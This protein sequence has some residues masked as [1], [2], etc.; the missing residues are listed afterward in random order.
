MQAQETIR[1]SGTV[2]N[3]NQTAL[4]N[5]T[6][7]LINTSYLV[8]TTSDG[9]FSFTVP[10]QNYILSISYIGYE[11]YMLE[12]ATGGKQGIVIILSPSIEK[13]DEVLVSAVRVS[14][15]SPVTHSNLDKKN[16]EKRN[17]GQDIP[18]LLNFLPAVV[19]TSDAGAGV[20]YTGIRV[21]GSDATRVNVTIN[22]IPYND[23]ESQGTFWVNLPD[24]TSSVENLQ[25]Q[26]GVGTSTNGSGAFGASLNLLTDASSGNAYAEINTAFG[27]YN[28]LKNTVKFSTGK[29][30]EH[31]ELSGRL[32]KIDSD[33]YIDRAWSDL[34]SY[35]LQGSYSDN[36][37]L[38]K[39]LTFGGH[40]KT[41][42]AWYGTPLARIKN[43]LEGIEQFIS[44]NWLSTD[45]A[46]NLRNSDRRYNYYTYDN[47]IDNYKQDHYQLHWS[48][49]FSENWS[50]N[51]G[52]NF[53]QGKGYFEQFKTN[54]SFY[55]YDLDP[56]TIGNEVIDET[57]LIRRRWL[58]NTFYVANINARYK[59]DNIEL[60]FG[61]SIS[62][63]E[64]DHYGE[65]IWSQYASQSAIR[66][67]YYQ[68]DANKNDS[69]I[70]G[71]LTYKL[72]NS[73]LLFGDLQGRFV[74]YNTSG[75]TSERYPIAIDKT[76]SF[77]NPKAGVTHKLNGNNSLYLSYA[78][79]QREPNRNDFE[80]GVEKA[81]KLNDFELGWRH[82]NEHIRINLNLYYMA[83]RDQLVLTGAVDDV[84]APIRATS[85][86]SYRT[87]LE[88]DAY[89]KLYE[90]FI[91][92]PN[93]GLSS[94]K[95]VDFFAPINGTPV[96]LG[97]TNLSF[98]PDLVISNTLTYSPI[99]AFQ[100]SLLSKYVGE[101]YMGNL[102]SAV[103]K[104]DILKS[105]FV[106]DLNASY[107]IH[108]KKILKTIRFTALINNLFNTKYISNGY[109]YTYDDN[110][111]NAGVTTTID[112]AGFY[113]QATRNF[114]VGI[115][116]LF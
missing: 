17:L 100:I 66:D 32:S 50:L 29:I 60:L 64:G 97:T 73:W 57:D 3:E 7:K 55:D 22:G 104:S 76:Y 95:N 116:L 51:L 86:K 99:L 106:N 78:R 40:E 69:N 19:T 62:T 25:L 16:L 67:R 96:D 101:Q 83:Y 88:I 80:N 111:S 109:Y 13:L 8:A 6:V 75:L 110:W 37:T 18:I 84:G 59:T 9:E 63:Y 41:Y 74:S 91:W 33:G 48:E 20:G 89:I 4:A 46:E 30:S 108:P 112:G 56:I 43:D 49:T 21:R 68:S 102:D 11:N 31:F 71:K 82:N 54:E 24:F 107:E 1:I 15:T 65:I 113:P 93:F 94:N 79:A 5:A 90:T 12:I 115:G 23:A 98:S 114:L 34:K 28:T 53:T 81:E 10:R 47:E 61:T 2:Y 103:S 77:F 85:G 87:G 26:R 35:F 44:D 45:E 72:N 14:A 38:I 27:S 58:D 92:Q 52:L 36:N 39:G 105:Y 42:Q 70:F